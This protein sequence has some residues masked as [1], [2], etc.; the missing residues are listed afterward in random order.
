M[1]PGVWQNLQILRT[2]LHQAMESA[3]Q[4]PLKIG[5]HGNFYC[6]NFARQENF[7]LKFSTLSHVFEFQLLVPMLKVSWKY[8]LTLTLLVD[9]QDHPDIQLSDATAI[10]SISAMEPKISPLGA[11]R[12][13]FEIQQCVIL[14]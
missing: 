9:K 2:S 8:I 12:R 4:R 1:K 13:V 10:K 7:Q 6:E 3:Y 11:S 14:S 5:P